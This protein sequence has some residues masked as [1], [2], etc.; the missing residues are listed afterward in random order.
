M[1]A[2]TEIVGLGDSEEGSRP[3]KDAHG[4]KYKLLFPQLFYSNTFTINKSFKQT[5]VQ[6]VT[7]KWQVI[8]STC[9]IREVII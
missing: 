1:G 7:I 2:G 8:N 9:Q 3:R 6:A 5:F 4:S